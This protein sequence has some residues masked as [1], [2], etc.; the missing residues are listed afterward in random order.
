MRWGLIV[1]AGLV[2]AGVW[3]F[4]RGGDHVSAETR[5]FETAIVQGLDREIAAGYLCL[6]AGPFP[7]DTRDRWR[8]QCDRCEDLNAAGLVERTAGPDATPDKPQWIYELTELGKSVYTTEEDSVSGDRSP[9]F[10]FG[11]AKVRRLV[12]SQ[13]PFTMGGQKAIGL[14]YEM[15]A[16]DPHPFLFDP[17]AQ[18]LKMP[19]PGR[20]VPK[21]FPPVTTTVMLTPWGSYL[22]TDPSFKYG[23]AAR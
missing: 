13:P 2:A 18:P 22:G 12:S 10:C 20:E 15:E 14:T 21:V 1:T 23:A 16:I 19:T 7:V 5:K 9:R 17:K 4:G 8:L 11:R 3:Y 6:R